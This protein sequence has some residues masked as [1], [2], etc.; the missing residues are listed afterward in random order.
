[1]SGAKR[2]FWCRYVLSS[3]YSKIS[4][5]LTNY[6]VFLFCWDCILIVGVRVVIGVGWFCLYAY[7]AYSS[8]VMLV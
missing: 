6:L 1:M 8:M 7:V 3:K 2:A 5:V 4:K